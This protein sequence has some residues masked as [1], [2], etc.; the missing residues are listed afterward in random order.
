MVR[1][2]GGWW[3]ARYVGRV[4]LRFIT[5]R[6]MVFVFAGSVPVAPLQTYRSTSE[7]LLDGIA[8][9]K[10]LFERPGFN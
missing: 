1:R 2:W 3:A 7:T 9:R 10:C 8:Y 4:S 5:H 6:Q